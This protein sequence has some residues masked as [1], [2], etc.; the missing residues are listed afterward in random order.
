[1]KNEI[2]KF[3]NACIEK[4]RFEE[5]GDSKSGN[6]CYKIIRSVY[7]QLRD[8]GRLN[9]LTTLL[10]HENP[11]VRLWAS[12]YALQI[13]PKQAEE[14]LEKLSAIKSVMAGFSAKITLQEWKKGNLKF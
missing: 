9:E 13:V 12:S 2:D 6:K 7:E 8:S 3:V 10:E 1:M 14:T 11:Y 5:L 4:G